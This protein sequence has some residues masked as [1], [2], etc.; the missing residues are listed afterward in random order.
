MGPMGSS[1]H[2]L[3]QAMN[4]LL[5]WLL[6]VFNFPIEHFLSCMKL[7]FEGRPY[8]IRVYMGNPSLFRR[9]YLNFLLML[10]RCI[11][12]NVLGSSMSI[13]T[14][15]PHTQQLSL[16][17]TLSTYTCRWAAPKQLLQR[18]CLP[19]FSPMKWCKMGNSSKHFAVSCSF[20]WVAGPTSVY[21]LPECQLTY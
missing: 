6:A 20:L 21:W 4:I 9:V 2:K 15:R 1:T 17:N 16:P 3:T 7:I 19:M 8:P 10:P 11:S 12:H 5:D 18:T 13:F 14:A